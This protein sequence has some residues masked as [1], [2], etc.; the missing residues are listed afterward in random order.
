MMITYNFK[1]VYIRISEKHGMIN[2]S[3]YVNA[4]VVCIIL[5]IYTSF[6]HATLCGKLY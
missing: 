6:S 1:F 2:H 5:C 4:R 3:S